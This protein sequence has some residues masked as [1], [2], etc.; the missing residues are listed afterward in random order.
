M[1]IK[2]KDLTKGDLINNCFKVNR[3]DWFSPLNLSFVDVEDI[4]SKVV[5]RVLL[6]HNDELTI[7]D[8]VGTTLDFSSALIKL[9]SGA[10]I[11]RSSWNNKD[12]WVSLQVP[13]AS[14]KMGLPYLFISKPDGRLVPWTPSQTDL[15]AEDWSVL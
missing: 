11:N 8:R 7:K 3:I 1:K 9:K 12:I 6:N 13:D 14:S 10:R 2:V 5:Y 15:M 4:K